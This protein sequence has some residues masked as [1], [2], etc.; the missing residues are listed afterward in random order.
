VEVAQDESSHA[1]VKPA[2]A[3]AGSYPT[4]VQVHRY[5]TVGFSAFTHCENFAGQPFATQSVFSLC[6]FRPP[7]A[8]ATGTKVAVSLLRA[9]GSGQLQQL[10]KQCTYAA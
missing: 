10:L 3:V 2:P 9:N 4:P 6:F 1:G 5:R 7:Q 8:R